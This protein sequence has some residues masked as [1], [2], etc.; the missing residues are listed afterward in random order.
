MYKFV[1]TRGIMYR[2]DS[3]EEIRA[4][5]NPELLYNSGASLSYRVYDES[6]NTTELHIFYFWL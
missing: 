4:A 2:Y 6:G 3:E 1:Y 5:I